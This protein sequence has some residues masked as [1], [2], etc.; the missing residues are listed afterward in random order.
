MGIAR[1]ITV[2]Y[3]LAG[4]LLWFMLS[5]GF[6]TVWDWLRW[7]D[8][9]LIGEN[10]KLTDLIGFGFAFLLPRHSILSRT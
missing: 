7:H 6:A 3:M 8:S 2:G 4:L 9:H 1:Y 10:L 5:K